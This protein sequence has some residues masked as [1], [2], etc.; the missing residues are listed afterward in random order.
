MPGTLG[1]ADEGSPTKGSETV[2][3]NI[4]I[5]KNPRAYLDRMIEKITAAFF[6]AHRYCMMVLRVV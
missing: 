3:E 2:G 6:L 4:G 1:W 5:Y